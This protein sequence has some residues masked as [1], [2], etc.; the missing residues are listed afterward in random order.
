ML[1]T[2]RGFTA[3]LAAGVAAPALIRSASA[4]GAT[5]KFGMVVPMSG[6][7][8][9]NREATCITGAKI[10]LEAVNKAGGVLG[11]PLELVTEDDQTTNPGAVLAFSKLA[12][13][14]GHRRVPG[15]DPLDP[16]ARDGARHDEDRQ[17]GRHRRHRPQPHP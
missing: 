15:L 12:S 13:Q 10:A 16:D 1:V 3:G 9:P 14:S 8:P 11:K 5:I 2:R 17:A 4:Q 6:V 7:R